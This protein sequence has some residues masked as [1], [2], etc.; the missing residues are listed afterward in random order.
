VA[1]ASN[2][3]GR[4][5]I[6][7]RPFPG[8]GGQWQVSTGG[9]NSPRWR[10]D[11]REIDFVAPD[12]TLMAAPAS[13]QGATFLPGAPV[14]LF[15]TQM[16]TVANRP[17]DDIARNGRFQVNTELDDTSTEPIHLL[18]NLKPPAK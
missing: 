13:A 1:Y 17:Q 9:G 15:Q 2:E 10:T 11:G 12:L 7:V 6:Y 5:E 3:S 18:Q 14:A 4:S 16:A 8:P